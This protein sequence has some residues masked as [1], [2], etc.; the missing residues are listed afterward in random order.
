MNEQPD[1]APALTP[2]QW[3]RLSF[4]PIANP[5]VSG[6]I[7][8]VA[9]TYAG[10]VPVAGR[11]ALAALALHGQPFGF[12]HAHVRG[13]LAVLAGAADPSAWFGATSPLDREEAEAL[14]EE[15]AKLIAALLPPED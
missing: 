5:D 9:G 10:D 15:A 13:I 7:Q 2:K 8:V 1:V 12:T 14:A 6:G 3:E 4:S 11:H